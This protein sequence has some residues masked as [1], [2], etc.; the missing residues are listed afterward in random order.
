MKTDILVLNDLHVGSNRGLFPLRYFSK[1]DNNPITQNKFQKALWR[2]FLRTL[3]EVQSDYPD[4]SG[5][6]GSG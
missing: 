5:M 4:I 3:D 6:V 2:L 1:E